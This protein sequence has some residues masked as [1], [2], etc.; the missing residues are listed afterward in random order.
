MNKIIEIGDYGK[1]MSDRNLF[2]QIVYTPLSD[3]IRLLNERQKD[4]LLMKKVEKLFKGEIPEILKSKKS[5]VMARQLAT[6]NYEN[7][8]FVSISKKVGLKPIFFEYTDDK[9]TS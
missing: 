3:A 5:A 9:F 1:I 2:N 7:R 4:P 6:P 8:M